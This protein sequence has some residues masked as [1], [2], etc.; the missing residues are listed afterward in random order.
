MATRKNSKDKEENMNDMI[1]RGNE[2]VSPIEKKKFKAEQ[3]LDKLVDT[4]RGQHFKPHVKKIKKFMEVMIDRNAGLNVEA[5]AYAAVGRAIAPS[6]AKQV[7]SA[8]KKAKKTQTTTSKTRSSGNVQTL[9]FANMPKDQLEGII[10]QVK[11]GT[12]VD[13]TSLS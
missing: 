2:S 12:K 3:E 1:S 10:S 13:V 11:S 4:P 5:M 9:D 8:N 6:I 7:T